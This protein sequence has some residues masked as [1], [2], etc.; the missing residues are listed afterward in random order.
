MP[1]ALT[2][3]TELIRCRTVPRGR[4][5]EKKCLPQ[6]EIEPRLKKRRKIETLREKKL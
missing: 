5:V 6:P 1:N 2:S 3:G 4:G